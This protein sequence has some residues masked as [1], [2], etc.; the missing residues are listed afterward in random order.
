MTPESMARA[1]GKLGGAERKRK[2][3]ND[4]KRRRQIASMGGKARAKS[5]KD[6]KNK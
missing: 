4:P 1:L 6:N 2:L 3:R 5:L